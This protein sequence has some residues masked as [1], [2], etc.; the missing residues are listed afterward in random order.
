MSTEKISKTSTINNNIDHDQISP[1]NGGDIKKNY[2]ENSK[3]N[4]LNTPINRGN[5]SMDTYERE[6]EF[7]KNL[8]EGWQEDYKQ[9]RQSWIDLAKNKT[10]REYPLLV[11]L[12]LSSKCNLRCP[13]CYTTTDEF[14][15]KVALKFMDYE[16]YK[17][18][19]LE[20]AGKVPA[21]RLSLRVNPHYIKILLKLCNLLN[22][23]E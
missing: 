7:Q 2:S 17:R 23:M 16:L 19:I 20:I 18:I 15:E 3:N 4:N 5:Y 9:Y 13:M 12:E 8:S 11:D 14:L 10:L 21:I 1:I 6:I 22:K